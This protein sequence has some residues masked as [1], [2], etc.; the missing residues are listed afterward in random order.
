MRFAYLSGL[1]KGITALVLLS[2]FHTPDLYAQMF[3]RDRTKAEYTL[4]FS[5]YVNWEGEEQIRQYS[6]GVLNSPLVYNELSFKSGTGKLKGKPFTVSYI[7]RIKDIGAV[8]VLYVAA[9]RNPDIKRIA[10]KIKGQPILMVTDSC[11][12]YE[13]I[14]INMLAL[15]LGGKSF[16][17]NKGNIDE[18]GLQVSD[19]ILYVGG[20]EEYLREIYLASEKEHE[21]VRKEL[22]DVSADLEEQK[23]MLGERRKEIDS[24]NLE[25]KGQMSELETLTDEIKDQQDVLEAKNRVLEDR[26]KELREKEIE[27]S[28]QND[29]LSGL[30]ADIETSSDILQEQRRN[31]QL[32]ARQIEA[33]TDVLASQTDTIERQKNIL[34]FFVVLFILGVGLIAAI[35]R[36][37]RIK[38]EA[39]RVLE[40]KNEAIRR[41]NI[42]ITRQK[43]EI[44]AQ[45]EHIKSSIYYAL[46][47]QQAILPQPEELDI[48][49]EN[50]IIYNPKDIVSGDFYWMSRV[51]AESDSNEKIL[52]AVVDCTGHGV[53]G[54]FLSI[55]GSRILN[56]IVTENAIY[57]PGSILEEMDQR[58]RQALKQDKTE[59]EDGMDVCLCSIERSRK[60]D[61][62]YG[63][64]VKI[65]F[66]GA[67]RPLFYISGS[68]DPVRLQGDRKGVGGPYFKDME[69]T[70]TALDLKRGDMLYL[71]TDGLADQSSPGGDKFGNK[72][73]M[74]ILTE[75]RGLPMSEQKILLDEALVSFQKYEKQRDDI[76]FL[77]IKL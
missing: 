77:G 23:K 15:N 7:K 62:S 28:Q 57:D 51:S 68:S 52:L 34:L 66:T 69:F 50:L 75:G 36:A 10:G 55:V 54:G 67:R 65:R 4:L 11:P 42:E 38:K 64:K 21:A 41:Q 26:E 33:Q 74:R 59:N 18:T 29:R 61:G 14:M 46:T 47:I 49:F 9:S 40:D 32:Q 25:I 16:E 20:R 24:L 8:H 30:M 73:I 58:V 63:E 3:T 5:G 72:K 45:R 71:T 22:A 39:N 70:E 27:I 44:T 2:L 31:I 60:R 35:I 13:H 48:Y 19:K 53:P 17:I 76:T 37:Y 12:D 56:A 6:I 1:Q 43:E